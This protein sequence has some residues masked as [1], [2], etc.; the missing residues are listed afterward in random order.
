M[1]EAY[2]QDSRVVANFGSC[3]AHDRLI[4]LHQ[5]S[6]Q[7]GVVGMPLKRSVI[8]AM[9]RSPSTNSG[10]NELMDSLLKSGVAHW[11]TA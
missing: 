6:P 1:Q 3:R 8:Q 5:I 9:L 7:F 10:R 11:S 4:L 2:A